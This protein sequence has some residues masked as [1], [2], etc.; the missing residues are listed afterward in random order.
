MK[1]F[2]KFPWTL[3]DPVSHPDSPMR[4]YITGMRMTTGG[5]DTIQEI[6]V[7][8]TN[9]K[10]TYYEQNGIRRA[11]REIEGGEYRFVEDS[12]D[13]FHFLNKYP[14]LRSIKTV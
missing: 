10:W 13:K 3:D 2:E 9:Q 7:S 1:Q 11:Y 5:V 12:A 6:T 14:E 4:L 8:A